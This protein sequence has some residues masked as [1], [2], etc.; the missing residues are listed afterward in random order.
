MKGRKYMGEWANG[1]LHGKGKFVNTDGVGQ[2]ELW[3]RGK[4]KMTKSG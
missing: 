1:K 3:K 2:E 4:S